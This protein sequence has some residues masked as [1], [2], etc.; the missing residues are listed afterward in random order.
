MEV[1]EEK[2]KYAKETTA[3]VVVI[4]IVVTALIALVKRGVL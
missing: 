3:I 4:I 2:M 1:R